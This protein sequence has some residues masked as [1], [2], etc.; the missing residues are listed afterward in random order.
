MIKKCSRRIR[1]FG[2]GT[3]L[4][5]GAV[6]IGFGQK[7][8]PPTRVWSVGP[9]SKSTLVTGV[10]FGAGGAT[11]TGPH[12][13]SQTGS[14]FSATRSVV[15]AGDRI[16][17]VSRE[18]G[19]VEGARVTVEVHQ[20]FSLDSQT[21]EVKNTRKIDAVRSTP[22][23]ATNDG[24]VI[25]VGFCVMWLTP[26]LKDAGNFD[27]SVGEH[28][29][30]TADNISPDGST[31][32]INSRP[33]LELV[34]TRTL[35]ATQLTAGGVVETSVSNKGFVTNN[36]QWIGEFPKDRSFVTY[37][38]AAGDHLVYHGKC[39][40]RPQFLTDDLILEPGCKNPL[41]IDIHGRLVRT[42]RVKGEFS[43]AGVSQNGKRFALQIGSFS[44]LHSLKRERFVVYSLNTGAP[45]AELAPDEPAEGQSWTAFSPD[46]SMIVV[47]SPLKLTLYRLP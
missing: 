24:H 22:V 34:D 3:L 8:P 37:T 26:D 1:P 46:G 25:A 33:G 6:A 30:G 7:L 17:L 21:G 27:C 39:G 16:V 31:L 44:R 18:M 29:V 36:T 15:F 5:L 32:G 43:Y 35:H 47:G 38:D 20:L 28:R 9:L 4:M 2:L 10:V 45:V 13:D 14:V 40:G 12:V 19:R 23:F 11:F 41:I 42:L